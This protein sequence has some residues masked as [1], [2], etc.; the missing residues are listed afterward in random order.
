MEAV[1]WLLALIV[2]ALV[3]FAVVG[4]GAFILSA[5]VVAGAL[6]GCGAMVLAVA[7]AIKGD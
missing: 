2:A 6:I 5:A 7:K 3:I 1:K 4:I